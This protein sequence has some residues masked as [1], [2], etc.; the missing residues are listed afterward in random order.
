[1]PT[2]QQLTVSPS[3]SLSFI[4][5]DELVGLLE[6]GRAEIRR[7]SHVEPNPSG[8]GWIA[9]MGPSGGGVLGPFRLRSEALAA[10]IQW[11]NGR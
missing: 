8:G 9:D 4:Y 7:A 10:E 5:S 11:L 6:L 2:T 1:M 3:G